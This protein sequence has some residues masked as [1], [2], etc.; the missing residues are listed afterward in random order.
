MVSIEFINYRKRRKKLRKA[1][2]NLGYFYI[3]GIDYKNLQIEFKFN[4]LGKNECVLFYFNFINKTSTQS[5][6]YNISFTI[7]RLNDFIGSSIV[8][9]IPL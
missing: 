9:L 1:K 2:S 6:I 3:M 5:V 8:F 7:Y 4:H